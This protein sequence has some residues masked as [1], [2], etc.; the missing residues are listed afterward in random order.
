MSP[1]SVRVAVTRIYRT[2]NSRAVEDGTYNF[3]RFYRVRHKTFDVGARQQSLTI[4]F[5]YRLVHTLERP[6]AAAEAVLG[7][8]KHGFVV[9]S[10][11]K[12]T[13]Y[14]CFDY[15]VELF[16]IHADYAVYRP[17]EIVH[18]IAVRLERVDFGSREEVV[19]VVAG[20]K[21]VEFV[22]AAAFNLF[23]D[24]NNRFEREAEFFRPFFEQPFVLDRRLF[25]AS[26]RFDYRHEVFIVK[27]ELA[28][29]FVHAVVGQTPLTCKVARHGKHVLVRNVLALLPHA[30][31][32]H[33][34]KSGRL[35]VQ[36]F[37]KRVVL[38]VFVGKNVAVRQQRA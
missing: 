28:K 38:V 1:G 3:V 29:L 37:H 5:F 16:V 22:H 31:R 36:A 30:V 14:V 9:E 21:R 27:V 32:D 34:K 10:E 4:E 20:H 35:D 12:P 13:S 23:R 15:V 24:R 33:G 25:R 8:G 11:R 18:T 19:F 7:D 6:H 17:R 2:G 26:E